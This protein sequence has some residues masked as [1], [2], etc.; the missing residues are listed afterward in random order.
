[1]T[2][3]VVAP[4]ARVSTDVIDVWRAWL[5]VSDDDWRALAPL[6]DEHERR[7]AARLRRPEHRRRF[8]ASHGVLRRV[9]GAYLGEEPQSLSIR[10]ECPRC[11]GPHGRPLVDVEG[12]HFSLS[13]SAGVALVAV[14]ASPV[15]VD[16]E[17][18]RTGMNLGGIAER[19]FSPAERRALARTL[20]S[21]L[22]DAFARCWTRKEAYVK[23]TGRGIFGGLDD[24]S[25]SI[26][27]DTAFVDDPTVAGGGAA[28]SMFNL[29]V[30]G[31]FVGA[32]I[33]DQPGATLRPMAVEGT[34]WLP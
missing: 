30:G 9:L 10:Y 16:V 24:F 21:E 32:V 3:M 20:P 34:T 33:V 26:E 18:V 12:F 13:H 1:M 17:Q 7:R 28:T 19:F 23:M 14:A 5:D 4:S 31:G 11:G 29:R 2:S 25:V 15:G 27:E 8:V 22:P 6:L